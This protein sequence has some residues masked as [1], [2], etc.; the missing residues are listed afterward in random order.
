[1][2]SGIEQ[3]GRSKI[4]EKAAK[5]LGAIVSSVAKATLHVSKGMRRKYEFRVF[6]LR[7]S[8]SKQNINPITTPIIPYSKIRN[9]ICPCS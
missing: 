4:H 2:S 5:I 8:A 1:M 7:L 3:N 6:V 9:G